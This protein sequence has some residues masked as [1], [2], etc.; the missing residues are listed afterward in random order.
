MVATSC[1][2]SSQ[3]LSSK[4]MNDSNKQMIISYSVNGTVTSWV[5]DI[6]GTLH[7]YSCSRS[8]ILINNYLFYNVNT[9]IFLN[10]NLIM[11]MFTLFVKQLFI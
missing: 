11:I 6:I 10:F 9:N 5:Q 3:D 2:S 7:T 4:K 8:D 1:G